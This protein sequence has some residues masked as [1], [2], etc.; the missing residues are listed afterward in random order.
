MFVNNFIVGPIHFNAFHSHLDDF[1]KMVND[2]NS[3]NS[4]NRYQIVLEV[5]RMKIIKKLDG[6]IKYVHK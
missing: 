2:A 6:Q 1:K 4:V 5:R 3:L